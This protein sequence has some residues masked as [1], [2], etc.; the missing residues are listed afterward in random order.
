MAGDDECHA[1][2]GQ[3]VFPVPCVARV[4]SA[5]E[6]RVGSRTRATRTTPPEERATEASP[7]ARG[8]RGR[9]A[10]PPGPGERED[11]P[12][13]PVTPRRPPPRPEVR[14]L[15]RTPLRQRRRRVPERQAPGGGCG[16]SPGRASPCPAPPGAGQS[17]AASMLARHSLPRGT[18]RHPRPPHLAAPRQLPSRPRHARDARDAHGAECRAS[19]RVPPCEEAQFEYEEERSYE[20]IFEGSEDELE[21]PARAASAAR[22]CHDKALVPVT[23]RHA[24]Q[25]DGAS[26]SA[27]D[28]DGEAM[29]ARTPPGS[30]AGKALAPC[31]SGQLQALSALTLQVKEAAADPSGAL[32]QPAPAASAK[33]VAQP[34]PEG[35]APACGSSPAS[36]AESGEGDR[37]EERHEEGPPED[38]AEEQ[39]RSQPPALLS[40]NA[41][42][43]PCSFH[44]YTSLMSHTKTSSVYAFHSQL[45]SLPPVTDL[46][47]VL[48]QPA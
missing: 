32:R 17:A 44:I 36:P 21:S 40:D 39:G 24:S 43:M 33:E 1:M 7:R 27:L 25:A 6:R 15:P 3:H 13:P 38:A 37:Q 35:D 16:P 8:G 28:G 48:L 47:D 26:D 11:P 5:D 14:A 42:D 9:G 22:A 12:G 23:A 10:R 18:H 31:P 19:A 29:V 34:A 4:A 20:E 46:E 45:M 2:C 41:T 30:Q